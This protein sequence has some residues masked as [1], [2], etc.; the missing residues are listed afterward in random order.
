LIT[1]RLRTFHYSD[2]FATFNCW[3]PKYFIHWRQRH[4]SK[5]TSLVSQSRE[6]ARAFL[7]PQELFYIIR[8][9]QVIMQQFGMR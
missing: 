5:T 8:H 4:S 3:Q 2:R 6:H 7:V 1:G 9:F